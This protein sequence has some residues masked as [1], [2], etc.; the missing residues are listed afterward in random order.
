MIGAGQDW[1]VEHQEFGAPISARP[2][3]S[4]LLLAAGQCAA[5]GC[6]APSAAETACKPVRMR[7]GDRLSNPECAELQVVFDIMVANNS[8][9]SA[10]D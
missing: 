4:H 5:S 8:R 2:I 3:A 7:C 6:A 9:C 10:P 1:V